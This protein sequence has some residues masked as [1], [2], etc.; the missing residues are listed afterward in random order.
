MCFLLLRSPQGVEFIPVA[1]GDVRGSPCQFSLEASPDTLLILLVLLLK[2][3]EGFLGG[4]LGD[5]GKIFD[6][7]PIQH[8]GTSKC[9]CAEAQRAFYVVWNKWLCRRKGL[10]HILSIHSTKTNRS[11]ER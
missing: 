9:A 1:L 11:E 8:F 5:S 6:A 7:Q 10:I 3:P 4:K 2:Q